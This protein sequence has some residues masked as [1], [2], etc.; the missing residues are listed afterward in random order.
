[1]RVLTQ[2]IRELLGGPHLQPHIPLQTGTEL[3][4]HPVHSAAE[5]Q[6]HP[7]PPIEVELVADEVVTD[8]VLIDEVPMDE[9][10]VDVAIAPPPACDELIWPEDE[11]PVPP[12]PP[13]PIVPSVQLP[14]FVLHCAETHDPFEQVESASQT[15]PVQR[16]SS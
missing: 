2:P 10:E 3:A 5:T 15:T 6:L 9:V 13:S 1:M 4:G 16:V 14:S 11:E 8:E 12:A 7:L